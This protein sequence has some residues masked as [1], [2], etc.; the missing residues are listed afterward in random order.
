MLN[1]SEFL[2]LKLGV[3]YIVAMAA[4]VSLEPFA[5]LL[6]I[7]FLPL[8]CRRV[9]PSLVALIRK[10]LSQALPGSKRSRCNGLKDSRTRSHGIDLDCKT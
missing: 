9:A 1:L 3:P 4:M 5:D 6:V 10:Q 2:R 7:Q 8:V